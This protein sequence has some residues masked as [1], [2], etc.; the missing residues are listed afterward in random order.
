M[1]SREKVAD[2]LAKTGAPFEIREFDDSTKN[3]ELAARV[4]G[5]SVGEIAKSVV[6]AVEGTEAVVVVVSGDKRVSLTKLEDHLRRTVRVARPEEVRGRTGYP[7]GGVPPFPHGANVRVLSD[8]S[9]ARF[10]SVWAA[11][12]APNSV[13]RMRTDD[14]IRLA[15]DGPFDLT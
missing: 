13:F 2:F 8:R 5:C 10:G 14:I 12:G 11:A 6:F 7:I 9:L 3:S 4:L 15:G 1:G